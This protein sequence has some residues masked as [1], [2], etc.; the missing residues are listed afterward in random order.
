MKTNRLSFLWLFA[1]LAV[2]VAAIAYSAFAEPPAPGPGD[3]PGA[4]G[5]RRDA[6]QPATAEDIARNIEE[7]S[8]IVEEH[9]KQG[10]DVERIVQAIEKARQ[11]LKEG[12]LDDAR[13]ILGKAHRMFEE[14]MQGREKRERGERDERDRMG[15]KASGILEAA[16]SLS[17]VG[18]YGDAAMLAEKATRLLRD[19]EHR[20]MLAKLPPEERERVM[21]ADRFEDLWRK[22][23]KLAEKGVNVS[24]TRK[25]LEAL[26]P[27]LKTAKFDEIM[28]KLDEIARDIEK[29]FADLR[30]KEHPKDREER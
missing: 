14:L 18:E 28:P 27:K 30:E 20:Q 2:I 4:A 8:R 6:P 1:A 5:D 3:N 22:V 13:E 11:L 19:I 26:K 12:K 10:F 25:A 17:R 7:F 16:A 23:E 24:K 29:L 21:I 15:E 9:A